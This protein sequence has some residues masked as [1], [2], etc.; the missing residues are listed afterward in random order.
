[1]KPWENKGAGGGAPTGTPVAVAAADPSATPESTPTAQATA[2]TL[3]AVAASAPPLPTSTVAPT[4]PPTPAATSTPAATPTRTAT[5]APPTATATPTEAQAISNALAD[6]EGPWAKGDWDTVI[7]RLSPLQARFPAN[8]ALKDKLYVA[9]LQKGQALEADERP[10]EAR[11]PYQAATQVD[12]GRTEARDRLQ[13]VNPVKRSSA[14]RIYRW[15]AGDAADDAEVQARQDGE[16]YTVRSKKPTNVV[17]V[18]DGAAATGSDFVIEASLRLSDRPGG[19]AMA[20]FQ[21]RESPWA[22]YGLRLLRQM[23]GSVWAD[24]VQARRT[25]PSQVDQLARWGPNPDFLA[26]GDQPNR[27]RIEGHGRGM[28]AWVNGYRVWFGDVVRPLGWSGLYVVALG[29]P[30][31]SV[32]YYEFLVYQP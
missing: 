18:P 12:P 3:A 2:P 26:P 16:G 17:A 29:V 27:L 30:D 7:A 19:A 31:T 9:Y 14:W 4:I 21:A 10:V 11:A 22:D 25:D 13:A 8:A 6:I 15:K 23:D 5:P 1:L 32:S 20:L 28:T 24:M